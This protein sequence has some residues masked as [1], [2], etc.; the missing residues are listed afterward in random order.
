MCYVKEKGKSQQPR[1]RN[2]DEYG[3]LKADTAEDSGKH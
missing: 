1:V 2:R 3:R